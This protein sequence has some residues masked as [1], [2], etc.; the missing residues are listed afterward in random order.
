MTLFREHIVNLLREIFGLYQG[1][2]QDIRDDFLS[3]LEPLKTNDTDSDEQIHS[4][5]RGLLIEGADACNRWLDLPGNAGQEK[6]TLDARFDL[7]RTFVTV[8]Y[9][10]YGAYNL[11]DVRLAKPY[12]LPENMVEYE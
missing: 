9:D 12:V 4:N 5:I 2:K 11:T 8:V 1:E 10:I 7:S 6:G 3:K